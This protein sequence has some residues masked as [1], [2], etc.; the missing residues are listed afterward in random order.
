MDFSDSFY[1]NRAEIL[2][3][4][5][6]STIESNIVDFRDNVT[7]LFSRIIKLVPSYVCVK[8]CNNCQRYNEI[9]DCTMSLSVKNY[10]AAGVQN[11]QDIL[12]HHLSDRSLF[13]EGCNA[14]S[15][16]VSYTLKNYIAIDVEYL[17]EEIPAE[18]ELKQKLFKLKGIICFRVCCT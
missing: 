11:L 9:P 18:I 6:E 15:V 5:Y 4:I 2:H 16:S 10:Y 1:N 8:K 7:S 14:R 12:K 3:P 17:H 13:C